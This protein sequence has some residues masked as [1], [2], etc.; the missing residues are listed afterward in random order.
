M[1]YSSVHAV[2][3]PR[4]EHP[5]PVSVADGHGLHGR[6]RLC[7]NGGVALVAFAWEKLRRAVMEGNTALEK[8][9]REMSAA[10]DR[11]KH[12]NE[13]DADH[14]SSCTSRGFWWF[15]CF[16]FQGSMWPHFSHHAGV[17]WAFP[18]CKALPQV[19]TAR[20]WLPGMPHPHC[21]A[22]CTCTRLPVNHHQH[23]RFTS[24]PPSSQPLS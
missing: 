7:R 4:T 6:R 23:H 14:H 2:R 10:I 12:H 3:G 20:A 15:W 17:T 5:P 16:N 19:S 9:V 1:P 22:T 18:T 24:S 13:V 11:D 8:S 21:R